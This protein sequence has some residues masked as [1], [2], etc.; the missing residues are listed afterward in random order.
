[1]LNCLPTQRKAS[2]ID[3]AWSVLYLCGDHKQKVCKATAPA[4]H[5]KPG[6]PR[7]SW[8]GGIPV[9]LNVVHALGM[10][11]MTASLSVLS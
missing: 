6:H 3:V 11:G 7:G 10:L 8:C 2:E 1:M 5:I 9:Y 4:M